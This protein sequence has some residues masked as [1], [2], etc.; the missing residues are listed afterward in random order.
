MIKK[1]RIYIEIYRK[2]FEQDESKGLM[3]WGTDEYETEEEAFKDV[4]E[5]NL[6]SVF[7]ILPIYYKK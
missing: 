2:Q 6:K 5:Y 4:E 3:V 7:T 1:Y